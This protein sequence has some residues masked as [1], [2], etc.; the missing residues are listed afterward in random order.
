MGRGVSF[1]FGVFVQKNGQ[2]SRPGR[3]ETPWSISFDETNRIKSVWDGFFFEIDGFLLKA[4]FL[5]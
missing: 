4:R 3:R 2:N 1:L 5:F